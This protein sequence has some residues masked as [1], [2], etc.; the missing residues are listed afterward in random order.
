LRK[1]GAALGG[2]RG[3]GRLGARHISNMDQPEGFNATVAGFL[4]GG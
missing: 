3:G 2:S 1:V 4:K